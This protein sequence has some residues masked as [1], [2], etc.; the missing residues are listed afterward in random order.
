MDEH[1]QQLHSYYK[2]TKYDLEKIT[3]EWSTDLLIAVDWPAEM[4]D[5][6]IPEAMLDTPGPCKTKKDVEVQDICST[7]TKTTSHSPAKGGND[8]EIGG[9]EVE[10]KKGEVTLPR[11]EEDPSKKRKITP[12]N[13]S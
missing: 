12:P 8:E 11:D 4:S 2:S 1:K 9:I 10:Q 5:M 6:D 13:P 7:S 3:K